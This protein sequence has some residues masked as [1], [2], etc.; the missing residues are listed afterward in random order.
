MKIICLFLIAC[1]YLT[2][3]LPVYAQTGYK[4]ALIVKKGKSVDSE[5]VEIML[6]NNS[7]KIRSKKKPFTVKL[8][9][10]AEISSIEYAYS[11]KPRYTVAA[12]STLAIGI[13]ALPL[14][15]TKT[16]KNWLTISTGK[17]ALILQLQSS[18]YRMLLLEM[19]KRGIEI[20]DS[21]DR[22]EKDENQPKVKKSDESKDKKNTG[23]SNNK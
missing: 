18:N 13:T 6:E 11:D 2:Y 21:G 20:S 7:V 12:L 8:I 9:S 19:R 22:D 10:L 4:A 15:A 5:S 14:F 23:K 1:L 17:D 3:H 16:K